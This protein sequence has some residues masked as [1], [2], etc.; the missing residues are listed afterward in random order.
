L[1]LLGKIGK[2]EAAQEKDILYDPVDAARLPNGDILVLEGRGSMVK[3]FDKNYEYISAFGQKGQ[4]PGDITFPFCLRLNREKDKI[5]I[6]HYRISCFSADG[7][8]EGGFK[9]EVI[10]A[11]GFVGELY[12]TSGMAVLSGSRVVLPSHPSIWL[13][14]GEYKLLS[15]YDETGAVIRSFGA[16][17]LYDDPALTVNANIVYSAADADDNIYVAY[18]YQN[19]ISKYSPEG[20]MV[21]SA[22]RPLP[23]EVKNVIIFEVFKSGN[24]EQK[25]PRPSVSSVTKGIYLDHKNRIWVLTFLKQPN[26][27]LTFGDTENWTACLVFEVFNSEGILLFKVPFPNARFDKFSIYDDRLYLVDSQHESCVY[28]Y[29]IVEEN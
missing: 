11:F 19:R 5:F 4:G 1:D 8:Y 14:S 9:P 26:R 27:F 17:K 18:G 12:R 13:D 21:F 20:T 22:D 3:R 23:Y 10:S 15:I 2:L 25:L 28:E 29:R 16:L 7:S 24:L 6:A